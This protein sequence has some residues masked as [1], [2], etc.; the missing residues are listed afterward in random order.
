MTGSPE[1]GRTERRSRSSHRSWPSSLRWPRRGSRAPWWASNCKAG[2]RAEA[3]RTKRSLREK[4]KG[5]E[6]APRGRGLHLATGLNGSWGTTHRAGRTDG[7]HEGS[8][9]DQDRDEGHA[10]E[11]GEEGLE[12]RELGV[13]LRDRI[14]KVGCGRFRH[15]ELIVRCLGDRVEA[16]GY[17]NRGCRVQPSGDS[18]GIGSVAGGDDVQRV[19]AGRGE[20]G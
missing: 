7:D 2:S 5:R 9:S 19:P 4:L 20:L 17:L 10:D 12:R 16:D 3:D 18:D 6:A 8:R 14:L 1:G 15:R 13:Q 11:D